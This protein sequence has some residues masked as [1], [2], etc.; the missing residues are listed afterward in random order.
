M[1]GKVKFFLDEKGFGFIEAEGKEYFVHYSC[2]AMKGHK[3]LKEGQT[4]EFEVAS[5]EKGLQA[6]NVAVK[7]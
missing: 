6:R 5:T 4:V 1:K 2:I 3:T 7:E